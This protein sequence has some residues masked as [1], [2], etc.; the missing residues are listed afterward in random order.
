MVTG[1]RA[2][3]EVDAQRFAEIWFRVA[4]AKHRGRVGRA[5]RGAGE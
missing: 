4:A 1:A 3:V 2:R 5:G